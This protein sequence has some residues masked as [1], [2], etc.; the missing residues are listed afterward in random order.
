MPRL[1]L[2][3]SAPWLILSALVLIGPVHAQQPPAPKPP[4][5]EGP[6]ANVGQFFPPLVEPIDHDELQALRAGVESYLEQT[7]AAGQ[8]P[9]LVFEFRP[10]DALSG[11]S[12]GAALDLA[13]FLAK[14]LGGAKRTVAY[15]PEPLKGYAVLAVLACDEIVMGPEATLG[16]I[17]P[18]GRP[19]ADIERAAVAEL[20]RTKGRDADLLLG[21]LDPSRDLR[22]IRTATGTHFVLKEHLDEFT[23]EHAVL[24]DRPAWEGRRG[25][26]TAERARETI[27]RLIAEDRARIAEWYS[28][29]STATDPTLAAAPQPMLIPIRGPINALAESYLLRQIARARSEGVNLLFIEIDSEGGL[30]DEAN[31]IA[32]ALA[33][34][35]GIKTIAYIEDRALGVSALVPLACD[36][37]VLRKGARLGNVRQQ[38]VDSGGQAQE[39]DERLTSVLADRAEELARQ[40]GHPSAVARAMVD[41]EAIVQRARDKQT[42]AVVLVLQSRV[43]AEPGRYDVL[44]TVKS[45]DGSALTLNDQTARELQMADRV[46]ADFSEL[47]NALGLRGKTIRQAARTWVDTLV[48]TLN[49]PWMRGLLL[50]V[51]FFMLVLELKLP[52][53]GLPAITAALAFLLYFWSSYLGG[54]ADQLEILLFL[55]G[56]VCMALELFV[57]PGF[58][59]FGISG[60]LMVLASV[61]MASHTFVLPSQPYEYRQMARTLLQLLAVVAGVVAGAVG[62]GKLFPRLPFFNR[63]VLKPEPAGGPE[64]DP[65][66]KPPLD[67]DAPLSFLLGETGRTTTIL[68]PSGKARFGELLVD[69]TA[70]GFYIE[71]NQ[72]VEVIDVRGSRVIVKRV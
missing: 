26:L 72:P 3:A 54:T 34:L 30:F 9:V 59:V 1:R 39:L 33:E 15:V 31:K 53:I 71:A 45:A 41:P 68:R 47:Q 66:Q 29:P 12:F 55:G 63:L 10:G 14:D 7:A 49:E 23:K 42:G 21:L 61:V 19:V 67:P 5:Q 32:A 28:L 69:V 43:E 22:Q 11:S 4:A 38:I 25:V 65:T 24:D 70:D 46:V 56:I 35:K 52:G 17:A 2:L 8:R 64:L 13:N 20:A 16:P 44:E 36:Q 40:K 37:I 58:G 62:L 57:F 51:G 27:V 18:E 6:G 48:D 60:V 50:F